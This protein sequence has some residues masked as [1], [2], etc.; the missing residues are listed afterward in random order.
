[1]ARRPREGR[2]RPRIRGGC[3]HGRIRTG[4]CRRRHRTELAQGSPAA[5]RTRPH[6]EAGARGAPLALRRGRGYDHR[7]LWRQQQLV[8]GMVLLAPQVLRP[9]G[10]APRERWTR[11][12]DRRGSTPVEHDAIVHAERL[13]GEVAG[14]VGARPAGPGARARD[15][16]SREDRRRPLPEGVLGRAAR[17]G[18]SS[19]GGRAARWSHPRRAER[20]VGHGRRRR[21]TLQERRRA[22][23][24]LRGKGP[25]PRQ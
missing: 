19:T 25:D 9:Q 13:S 16:W 7:G 4:P 21:R 15:G 11:E 20:S 8:R 24:D 6:H 10:R 12:V 23:D 2:E 17:A 1:M 3:R 22:S 18:E 14:R 5:S